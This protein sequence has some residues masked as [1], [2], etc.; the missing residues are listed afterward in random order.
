M[1]NKVIAS[2]YAQALFDE[3]VSIQSEVTVEQDFIAIADVVRSSP[4]LRRLFRSPLIDSHKKKKVAVEIFKDRVS[5]LT[6]NFMKLIL[7]KG[8]EALLVDIITAFEDLIDIQRNILRVEITSA[9]PLD[10]GSRSSL[11]S[12]LATKTGQN[13]RATYKEDEHLLGGVNV[14]IVDKVYDGSLR[15]QLGVLKEKLSGV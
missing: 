10:D 4:E 6:M 9:K 15:S 7:D 2:R 1:S 13:I 12:Q 3:A 8:R 14:R 5:P 11:E